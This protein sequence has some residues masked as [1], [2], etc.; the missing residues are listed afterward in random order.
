MGAAD[1]AET[2]SFHRDQSGPLDRPL[3]PVTW[4][5]Q[6]PVLSQVPTRAL[7]DGMGVAIGFSTSASGT[8]AATLRRRYGAVD[9][10]L[11][12]SGTSA[13]ILALRRILPPGG[14]VAY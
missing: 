1:L 10:L 4:R 7:V 5:R 9:A 3:P 2:P 6:P 13:L 8:V 14:T 11:T 12:D